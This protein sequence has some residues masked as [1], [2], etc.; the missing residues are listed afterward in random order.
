MRKQFRWEGK[1]WH[2]EGLRFNFA[3][4]VL[5]RS[6]LSCCCC[7]EHINLCLL[8]F[9]VYYWPRQVAQF[10]KLVIFSYICY[11]GPQNWLSL[12]LQI[13]IMFLQYTLLRPRVSICLE[14]PQNWWS[15]GLQIITLFAMH[16]SPAQSK[17]MFGRPTKLV[18]FGTADI[19]Y[20]FAMYPSTAQGKYMFGRSTKLVKFGTADNYAFCNA[21]F[22]G[23]E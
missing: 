4:H 1:L 19:N 9:T 3:C 7:A 10:W 6:W 15:L 20:V 8:K 18:K 22:S 11:Y 5:Y 16:P 12:W 23:P 13:L 2:D 21:P 14:G 17:C